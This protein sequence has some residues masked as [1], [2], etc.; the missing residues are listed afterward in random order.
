MDPVELIE[1]RPELRPHFERLNLLWLEGHSLLEPVDLEYLRN[2][3]DLILAGGGKVLFAMQGPAVLGTGAVMRVSA[4][5]FELA[6][7]SVDPAARGRR[8]GRLLCEALIA[9]A[10]EH[11]ARELVLTTHTS[12]T[13]AIALYESLGFVHEPLPPDVRYETANVFMRLTLVG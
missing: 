13:T 3:E 2:P 11:A 6:K 9:F 12:L 5:T 4:D 7:L 8:I 1:Y 10:R